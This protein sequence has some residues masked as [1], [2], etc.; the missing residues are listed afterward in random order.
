MMRV[1]LLS[2]LLLLALIG[3]GRS[4]PAGRGLQNCLSEVSPDQRQKCDEEAFKEVQT[5]SRTTQLDGGWRLVMTRDPGGGADAVSVM[6][7]ADTTKS[8]IGLAGL[9]LQCGRDGIEVVLIVLERLPRATRLG[10]I[11]T[12]GSKRT[13]FEAAVVQGGEALLLPKIA[14]NLAAGEWQGA[15]ELAV[16]IATKPVP[17]HGAVPIGGLSNALRYLSQNCSAG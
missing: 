4:E 14:S 9:S 16:E 5:R 11:L 17:I 3:P 15:T 12:A 7:V 8:D 2:A 1:S 6:H 10:V 13:E